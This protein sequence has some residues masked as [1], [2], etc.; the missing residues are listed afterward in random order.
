M[1][2]SSI[3][4]CQNLFSTLRI[5]IVNS[6]TMLTKTIFKATAI[7]INNPIAPRLFKCFVTFLILNCPLSILTI[8][9]ES[10]CIFSFTIHCMWC[11]DLTCLNKVCIILSKLSVMLPWMMEWGVQFSRTWELLFMSWEIMMLMQTEQGFESLLKLSDIIDFDKV[12]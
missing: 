7:S 10:N 11:T 2:F 5:S 9:P 4:K 1:P 3:L 6:L 12:P 8:I